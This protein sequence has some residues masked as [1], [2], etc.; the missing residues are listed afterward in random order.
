MPKTPFLTKLGQDTRGTSAVE[1]GLI[2]ALIVIAM[3]VGLTN[4]SSQSNGVWGGFTGKITA[5]M[6]S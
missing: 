6:P 4:L 1:Y 5:V 3:L 2:L